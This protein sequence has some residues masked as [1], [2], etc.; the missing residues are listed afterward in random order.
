MASIQTFD[1]NLRSLFG[2]RT[3]NEALLS[4][5]LATSLFVAAFVITGILIEPLIGY[6]AVG[7]LFLLG[8]LFVS[9]VGTSGPAVMS[10]VMSSVAWNFFFIP[11]KFTLTISS[12]ED[13][14]LFVTYFAVA[15]TT[16]FLTK[17]IRDKETFNR[18]VL[19]RTE[20][21]FR[22][23]ANISNETMQVQTTEL[24][25]KD[26]ENALGSRC[27]ILLAE[28]GK[29]QPISK[30]IGMS[31]LS[32]REF[33]TA[34]KAIE[35]KQPTFWPPLYNTDGQIIAVPLIN[36]QQTLGVFFFRPQSEYVL[37]DDQSTILLAAARLLT[38]SLIGNA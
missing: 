11:P 14:L 31:D 2:L 5:Y 6:H 16:S 1:S 22:F 13:V 34:Q 37:P 17:S 30:T 20:T 26:L 32:E 27:G 23:L 35:T 7:F 12:A 8:V 28:D 9:S 29:L 15:L 21:L 3:G 4:S 33:L 19:S 10:A 18:L 36:K 38:C 24:L 25:L